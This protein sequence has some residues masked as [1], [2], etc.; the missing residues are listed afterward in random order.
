MAYSS[1][2]ARWLWFRLQHRQWNAD[3]V[4][5]T[6]RRSDGRHHGL[7]N[8]GDHRFRRRL[9]TATRDGN[10][11]KVGIFLSQ[12]AQIG[13]GKV[14][15][16]PQGVGDQNLRDGGCDGALHH[17]RYRTFRHC[18][19]DKLMS[20]K[21]FTFQCHEQIAPLHFSA[22]SANA[23]DCPITL[24]V[25]QSSFCPVRNVRQPQ[26]QHH[27]HASLRNMR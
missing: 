8:G 1:T 13:G 12:T 14:A 18:L 26:R 25:V 20:I 15:Q 24:R 22:V 5:E 2:N 23:R 9:P 3:L 27:S 16:S 11:A 6:F 19:S 7:D 17:H 10:D 4:V 21:P